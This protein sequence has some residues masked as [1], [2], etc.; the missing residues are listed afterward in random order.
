MQHEYSPMDNPEKFFDMKMCPF[1][2]HGDIYI[3]KTVRPIRRYCCK[4]CGKVWNGIMVFLAYDNS[5]DI[6]AE[7]YRLKKNI[8]N[9]LSFL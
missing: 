7:V 6:V 3:E 5:L 4:K 9:T 8:E 2:G 1:C